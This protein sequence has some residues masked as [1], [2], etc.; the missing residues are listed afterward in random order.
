MRILAIGDIHGAS[1][2]LETLLGLI[3]LRPDD[4]L[5]TLGDYVDRGPDS[6]GVIDRLL[7]LRQEC[8]LVPLRGNHELMMLDA[9]H[10]P[11]ALEFWLT[12]GGREAMQSYAREGQ[13]P[14]LRDVPVEHWD[15]MEN[16]CHDWYETTRYIFVHA[17]V[18]S[19]IER[20][21][22]Q[23]T[24]FLHWTTILRAGRH[25]SGKIVVCGH[26]EQRD[27]EPL[28]LGHAICIDTW[29]YHSTG[30]LTCLDVQTCRYWQANQH[31]D[32][33][34]GWLEDTADHD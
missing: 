18:E 2:A 6:S 14:H 13:V 9:R 30:W 16:Q 29:A 1:T 7:R 20:M 10:H 26:T 32:T 17:S 33:R 12:V 34:S 11:G 15:F 4:R 25:I 31:G 27:G 28:H 19:E 3:N 23:V 21:E 5:V 8:E 22:D 24:D